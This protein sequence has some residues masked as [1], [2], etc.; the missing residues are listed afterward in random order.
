M[1]HLELITTSRLILEGVSAEA[2]NRIFEQYDK[3]QIMEILGHTSD[4]EYALELYKY[5]N[6]YASYNR[7]FMLFL[8][9]DKQTNEVIGRCGLHN[10]NID[11][12]RAEVGYVIYNNVNKEKGLMSETL[13]AVLDYGFLTLKLHRIEALVATWNT[14]SLRLL[15]KNN[16]TREGVLRGHY[17]MDNKFEDSIMF[18]K[19]LQ[20]HQQ[21]LQARNSK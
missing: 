13:E 21:E 14:P 19:L 11:H 18:S 8:M 7:K 15:E 4:E 17:F 9:R 12:S 1:I 10:W 2:M 5:Q 20:E 16:F 3:M 6:G